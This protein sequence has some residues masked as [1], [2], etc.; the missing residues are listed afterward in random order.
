MS[1]GRPRKSPEQKRT[2][3]VSVALSQEE[4]DRVCLTA[5]RLRIKPSELIRLLVLPDT[6]TAF[7]FGSESNTDSR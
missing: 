1:P 5:A 2:E 7:Y 6:I 4:H 3:R